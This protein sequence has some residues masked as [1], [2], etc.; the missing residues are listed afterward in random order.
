MV[1][2]HH[3]AVATAANG[4]AEQVLVIAIDPIVELWAEP[5]FDQD[6]QGISQTCNHQ[7]QQQIPLVFAGAQQGA[8]HQEAND[9]NE[10]VDWLRN[11]VLK[12]EATHKTFG[13]NQRLAICEYRGHG[14]EDQ[15]AQ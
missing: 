12:V 4:L 3:G 2:K 7:G 10:L 5:H 6:R 1:Q 8:R 15:Q 11:G 14:A 9:A 13:E